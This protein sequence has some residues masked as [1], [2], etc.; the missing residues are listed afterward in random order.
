MLGYGGIDVIGEKLGS[1]LVVFAVGNTTLFPTFASDTTT[2]D[3][4]AAPTTA[5]VATATAT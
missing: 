5:V 2:P 4:M 3:E 1:M